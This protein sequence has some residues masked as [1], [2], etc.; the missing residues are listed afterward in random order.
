MI[1]V[2]IPA[3][4]E[5]NHI[6]AT[7]RSLRETAAYVDEELFIVVVDDG[8]TDCTAEL[9]VTLGCEVVSLPDRGFSAL[10][11][12]VLADTH[13]AGFEYI[14]EYLDEGSYSF[15]MVVGADTTFDL[16]Y[17]STLLTEMNS[18]ESLVM[19]AG[20][21]NGRAGNRDAVR[22]SGRLIRHSFWSLLGRRLPNMFYSWESYPILYALTN[23]F[24][25]KTVIG[26]VMYSPREPLGKVDWKRYGIG[27]RENGSIILYVLLRGLKRLVQHGDV[28]G[29]WRLLLGYIC[30]RPALYDVSLRHYNARRQWKKLMTLGWRP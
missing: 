8:S 21:L 5:E 20:V 29:G 10:G 18:S 9:A 25:V 11:L 7:V 3:K 23:G 28:R 30:H 27:M 19:C 14:D 6:A 2:V 26:A 24:Q 4:N 1:P 13:N 12:P 17:L 16:R 22:G 15:L